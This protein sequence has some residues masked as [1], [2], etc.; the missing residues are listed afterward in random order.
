M[1]DKNLIP[2]EARDIS[3][4]DVNA[5]GFQAI[6]ASWIEGILTRAGEDA[7][8]ELIQIGQRWHQIKEQYFKDDPD[9]AELFYPETSEDIAIMEAADS[10]S[11]E[12]YK[13]KHL[14]ENAIAESPAPGL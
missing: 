5:P 1:T 14:R 2:E 13:D 10:F 3:A 6:V 4:Y 9:D 11:Q 12:L 7:L 8:L